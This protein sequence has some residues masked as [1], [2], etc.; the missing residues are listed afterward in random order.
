M[1]NDLRSR[2]D[3]NDD[4]AVGEGNAELVKIDGFDPAVGGEG[5][6]AVAGVVREGVEISKVVRIHMG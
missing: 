2:E 4:V 5:G 6:E 3:G 1:R